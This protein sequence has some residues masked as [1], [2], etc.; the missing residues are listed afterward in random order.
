[1]SIVNTSTIYT[2]GQ[3]FHQSQ[4]QGSMY[5]EVSYTNPL[6]FDDA[7][8][9]TNPVYPSVHSPTQTNYNITSS[10]FFMGSFDGYWIHKIYR[11]NNLL[12]TT[13]TLNQELFIPVPYTKI[14]STTLDCRDDDD[15]H[16]PHVPEPTSAV[17]IGIAAAI[18]VFRKRKI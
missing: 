8:N 13:Q 17:L 7:L 1:M 2:E 18:T 11:D 4:Y 6:V 16:G 10:S 5:V 14:E 12:M 9:I 15:G 3:L